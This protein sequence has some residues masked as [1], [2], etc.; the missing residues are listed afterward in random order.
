MPPPPR[1]VSVF[2]QPKKRAPQ[3]HINT[4][5][6]HHSTVSVHHGG[7][8]ATVPLKAAYTLQQIP[9]QFQSHSKERC[10]VVVLFIH[11][12]Y[13]F[14][15]FWSPGWPHHDLSKCVDSSLPS[16]ELEQSLHI[17]LQTDGVVCHFS[18]NSNNDCS[19]SL[20]KVFF[21]LATVLN[22][23]AELLHNH[24]LMCCW[25]CRIERALTKTGVYSDFCCTSIKNCV[26]LSIDF[27]YSIS[28]V[29]FY[30]TRL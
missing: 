5:I 8:T 11:F 12:M 26:K 28:C 21:F 9:I 20:S 29:S 25:H 19:L 4:L 22:M 1:S 17:L 16:Y 13:V 27:W 24:F 3:T 15:P 23:G 2:L 30:F 7:K 18:D 6:Y 14:S 10:L